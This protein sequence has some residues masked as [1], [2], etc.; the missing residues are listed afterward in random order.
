M[1]Y[2]NLYV[3]SIMVVYPIASADTAAGVRNKQSSNQNQRHVYNIRDSNGR[4]EDDDNGDTWDT[5][6]NLFNCKE[7]LCREYSDRFRRIGTFE[8]TF[9]VTTDPAVT[10]V[11]HAPR[12]CS[13]HLREEIKQELDSMVDLGAE[14]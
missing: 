5:T 11:V 9:H 2:V 4:D 6:N 8:G 1:M 14:P 7:D 12:R 10:P 3:S 13:I